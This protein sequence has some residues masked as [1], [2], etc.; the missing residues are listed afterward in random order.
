MPAVRRL[1]RLFELDETDGKITALDSYGTNTHVGTSCGQLVRL[2]ISSLPSTRSRTAASVLVAPEEATAIGA[3][4]P[5]GEAGAA[6][7]ASVSTDESAVFT[8]VTRRC[9]V[10]ASGAAVQQ[11]QHSRSQNLLFVLCGGRLQLLHADT[12]AVLS[13][14]ATEVSSFSVAPPLPVVGSGASGG[15]GGDSSV[16]PMTGAFP[17]AHTRGRTSRLTVGDDDSANQHSRTT[18]HLR[19]S[20][21]CSYGSSS[22][23]TLQSTLATMPA[24]SPLESTISNGGNLHQHHG[25]AHHHSRD[26]RG[27]AAPLFCSSSSSSG[28]RAH[29]VCVAEKQKKELAVYVVDRVSTS[30]SGAVSSVWPSANE[31]IEDGALGGSAALSNATARSSPPP[32]RVVLRQ[33]YVLPERAQCVLMCSPAPAMRRGTALPFA[34]S[35]GALTGDGVPLL[36]ASVEAGLS[37]CVGMRREVSLLSLIGGSTWCVLRLDGTRPPLLSVGSDHN[38]F[39]VRTQAPNTVMEVG[40][41]PAAAMAGCAQDDDAGWRTSAAA[42]AGANPILLRTGTARG[43]AIASATTSAAARGSALRSKDDDLVMGDVFQA[44]TVVEFVLARFPHIFLFTAHHCDVVSLLEYGAGVGATSRSQRVP[45]P[46]IR[47]GALRGQ[48]TSV[49]VASD[50]TVWMLQLSPLRVQL[51]EMVTGGNSEAAFQLLAFHRRRAA[52]VAR[53]AAAAA[54]ADDA[55]RAVESDLH[56]MAGFAALHRGE[57]AEA[58]RYLRNHV[59]PREVLLALPDCIPPTTATPAAH[60]LVSGAP[61]QQAGVDVYVLD[62]VVTISAEDA[63]DELLRQSAVSACAEAAAAPDTSGT[64]PSSYWDSWRGPCVYNSFG[65]NVAEAWRVAFTARSSS[66]TSMGTVEDFVTS[67]FDLLKAEVRAWFA[68][69]LLQPVSNAGAIPSAAAPPTVATRTS[70]DRES[71]ECSG[72][73]LPIATTITSL[74]P[75]PTLLV[76]HRR[77]ME[78]ASLVLAWEAR[79]Y[80]MAHQV[81]A[82]VSQALRVEDCADMLRHLREYRLLAVLQFRTG[83]GEAC[84]STLRNMVSVSAVLQLRHGHAAAQ[85]TPVASQLSHWRQCMATLTAQRR[86]NGVATPQPTCGCGLLM[87]PSLAAVARVAHTLF[88]IE[89]PFNLARD[90]SSREALVRGIISYYETHHS[91]VAPASAA[92]AEHGEA[93]YCELRFSVC[94]THSSSLLSFP[95]TGPLLSTVVNAAAPAPVPPHA[96]VQSHCEAATEPGSTAAR[97]TVVRAVPSALTAFFYLVEKLDVVGVKQ[98]LSRHPSLAQLRDEEGGTA[99]HVAMSQLDLVGPARTCDAHLPDSPAPAMSSLQLL[100][101]LNGLLVHFGC[102]VGLLN[103]YG[104]SCLDVAAVAC[105]GNTTAFD[106]VTAALLAAVEVRAVA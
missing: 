76:A 33:R 24:A 26:G 47:Y 84:L 5:S 77:A 56:C 44:D 97:R 52:A 25:N 54:D 15:V 38:T 65:G 106:I 81:V 101:S 58:I 30:A 100:C 99:L 17:S 66:S 88:D 39:L 87:L 102:P 41:P 78:Y 85:T 14:I 4:L 82:S 105:A 62:H 36:A 60:D 23:R 61:V 59:D 9:A 103:R 12:Y 91:R 83:Q 43:A 31:P 8:T 19:T 42:A 72:A 104:W 29:V 69:E 22:A 11:L 71:M 79:D 51:A 53:N 2:S 96:A 32:P 92:A 63:Y 16:V 45:L 93:S 34:A 95:H 20:S 80:R 6:A 7:P 1:L 18:S 48:G 70:I 94:G 50:R 10:S 13:T 46:G 73:S 86:C 49:C 90:D 67:R 27:G 98:L 55:L 37:V 21:E 3:T 64:P 75:P 74:L 35:A 28:S 57:V 68:E 89:V 40:V